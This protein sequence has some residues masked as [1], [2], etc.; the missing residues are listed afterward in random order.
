MRTPPLMHARRPSICGAL[1]TLFIVLLAPFAAGAAAPTFDFISMSISQGVPT[2][3]ESSTPAN[4]MAGSAVISRANQDTTSDLTVYFTI[5][6]QDTNYTSYY[7]TTTGTNLVYTPSASTVSLY[8]PPT[9]AVTTPS[10]TVTPNVQ[11]IGPGIGNVTI[12]A[13]TDNVALIITPIDNGLIQGHEVVLATI[14]GDL[15]NPITY[16]LNGNAVGQV[17][18]AEGDM[19]MTA[20]LPVPV[21]Y[22]QS[23]P[24]FSFDVNSSRRAVLAA[25]FNVPTLQNSAIGTYP[26]DNDSVENG[27]YLFDP[28]FVSDPT[29]K[30]PARISDSKY[31]AAQFT[32]SAVISSDYTLT[33]KIT[34]VAPVDSAGTSVPVFGGVFP[35][36]TPDPSWILQSPGPGFG[37][38]LT[39][40]S[41]F[42]YNT[43]SYLAGEGN[44]N[45]AS[46]AYA[47]NTYSPT[48]G[49]TAAGASS[50]GGGSSTST[51]VAMHNN[52]TITFSDNPQI[53]YTIS[54]LT[55]SSITVTYLGTVGPPT[56]LVANLHNASAI[57]DI[58]TPTATGW[59]VNGPYGVGAGYTF[60][61]P[62]LSW[63]KVENGHNGFHYGDVIQFGG[64]SAYYVVTGF[65]PGPVFASDGAISIRA[66]R[67]STYEG[68][69]IAITAASVPITSDFPVTLDASGLTGQIIVPSEST[70][71]Q[72][73]V[74]PVDSGTPTGSRQV[75][76]QLIGNT[77][78][79]LLN[80][81]LATVNIADDASTANVVVASNATSPGINGTPSG[82][83][84]VTFSKPFTQDISVPYTVINGPGSPA[85][86]GNDY[87]IATLTANSPGST[88]G[89]GLAVLSA[90]S[91]SLSIP[92]YPSSTKVNF[93]ETIT[94]S[95]SQS[96]D[97]L[98]ATGNTTSA[99]PT[100]T[101][102]LQPSTAV[103]DVVA[104]TPNGTPTIPVPPIPIPTTPVEAVSGLGEFNIV[105]AA[106]TSVDLL[107]NFT[108]SATPFNPPSGSTF[109]PVLTTDYL[110]QLQTGP[111]T[112]QTLTPTAGVFQAKI[113]HG[114]SSVVVFARPVND[115]NAT[116]SFQLSASIAGGAGYTVQSPPSSASSVIVNVIPQFV[117]AN[118]IANAAIGNTPTVNFTLA[119]SAASTVNFSFPAVAGD[120]VYGT[121]YIARPK[122]NSN[123]SAVEVTGQPGSW[124]ATFQGSATLEIDIV[125]IVDPNA[126]YP[127]TIQMTVQPGSGFALNSTAPNTPYQSV[128]NTFGSVLDTTATPNVL[129]AF[130]TLAQSQAV[131]AS[132]NK[133]TPGNPNTG[134]SGGCG[135]GSGFAT[136]LGL[137][138]VAFGLTLVRR[139]RS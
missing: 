91:T 120:A 42:D 29:P 46:F 50:S 90:G 26:L 7:V 21:A 101:M 136:L 40:D 106:P 102:I 125:G 112:F 6:A 64:D 28:T 95:L 126:T 113:L 8:A 86:I 105:T 138:L 89:T 77:N 51:L 83:F 65:V 25:T 58:T 48:I 129:D 36:G 84:V 130:I 75:N 133:P 79:T 104:T 66:F 96:L 97:Y 110:I 4:I 81:S 27:A 61:N 85:S 14:T 116:A 49:I 9:F 34:G 11:Y 13:G 31:V 78:F 17:V 73:G 109:V 37:N 82:N 38:Y 20:T 10:T 44:G 33:Y 56:G 80:P 107:V 93:S 137:G 87:T 2:A 15:A 18:V 135:N 99:N 131:V 103:V 52:D 94:L 3:Q 22:K 128:T 98:L 121:D 70:Q 45:A 57:T 1:L 123:A 71:I 117:T 134:S 114:T 139:R 67:N 76:M 47:P 59:A 111:T 43:C 119:S 35:S 88:L 127:L 16:K 74:T 55:S 72:F 118:A 24:G 108:I 5:A 41:G 68:I 39:G 30:V 23:I 32:G 124:V 132:Q 62:Q 54:T 19:T 92:V 69:D 12:P 63:I 122:N 100:A 60:S 53:Y 115:V